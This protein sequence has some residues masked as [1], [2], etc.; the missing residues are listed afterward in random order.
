MAQFEGIRNTLVNSSHSLL[1]PTPCRRPYRLPEPPVHPACVVAG[2]IWPRCPSVQP[3]A[4]RVEGC[5]RY[6]DNRKV[7]H[8]QPDCLH[9]TSSPRVDQTSVGSSTWLLGSIT[10]MQLKYALRCK[11]MAY[12][13]G[14]SCPAF[15]QQ[16]IQSCNVCICKIL[17]WSGSGCEG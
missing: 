14:M 17:T 13:R 2:R 3:T 15:Y 4:L 7:V 9:H 8:N 5:H 1:K 11:D 12:F 6:C 16:N 10:D